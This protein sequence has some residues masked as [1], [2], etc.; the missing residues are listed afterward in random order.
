MALYR[1]DGAGAPR[2]LVHTYSCVDGGRERVAF[3]REALLVALGMEV[4]DAPSDSP[5]MSAHGWIQFPCRS[6]HLRALK[7]AFLDLCKLETGENLTTKP[8]TVFDK[9]ANGKEQPKAVGLAFTR[10]ALPLGR[11]P[12]GRQRSLGA[13]RSSARWTLSRLPIK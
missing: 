7:R 4:A 10:C 8:L 2:L 11:H 3:I 9:K 5:V 1:T 6:D 12:D 13:L